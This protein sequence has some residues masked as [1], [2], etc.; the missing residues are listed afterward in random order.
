MVAPIFQLNLF[1]HSDQQN[2]WQT[3]VANG[4]GSSGWGGRTADRMANQNSSA[5][6]VILSVAGTPIFVTDKA[7]LPLALAPAPTVPNAT[8]KL[9]GFPNPPDNDARYIALQKYARVRPE[10]YVRARCEPCNHEWIRCCR[11]SEAGAGSDGTA[12]SFKSANQSRQP[13]GTGRQAH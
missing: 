6:P 12:V 9:D 3:S 7:R 2:Q 4:T 1:S 10:R 5:L 13:I 8:L 11:H